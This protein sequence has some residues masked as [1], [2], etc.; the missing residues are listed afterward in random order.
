M[1]RC[2]LSLFTHLLITKH[3]F[4]STRLS[5]TS[6][7]AVIHLCEGS[8]EGLSR[9]ALLRSALPFRKRNRRRLLQLYAAATNRT[10]ED[11]RLT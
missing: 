9:S 6:N 3:S 10:T 1:V 2:K 5:T 4:C 7:G 11:Q 8:D